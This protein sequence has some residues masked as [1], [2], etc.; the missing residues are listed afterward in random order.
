MRWPGPRGLWSAISA[1]QVQCCLRAQIG[2]TSGA[3]SGTGGMQ[4][5]TEATFGTREDQL[6]LERHGGS[7][8]N[9]DLHLHRPNAARLGRRDLALADRSQPQSI[10][11]HPPRPDPQELIAQSRPWLTVPEASTFSF[12]GTALGSARTVLSR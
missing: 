3:G 12:R 10:T 11:N 4:K 5:R 9:R 2:G 7:H 6:N 8:P 1:D